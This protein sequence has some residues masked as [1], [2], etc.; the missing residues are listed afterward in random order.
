MRKLLVF[1]L[2]TVFVTAAAATAV[3][4]LNQ[5][6]GAHLQGRNEVPARDTNAQGQALF[7]LS[8]DGQSMDYKLIAANIENA[9]MGHIHIGPTEGTGPIAV[10]L[11]PG[12]AATPIPLA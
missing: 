4:A 10:W 3:A 5:N 2:V 7:H 6:F 12:T 8:D 11:F 1:G 9:F